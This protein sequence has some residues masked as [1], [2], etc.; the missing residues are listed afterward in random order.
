MISNAGS[1]TS[2]KSK[3]LSYYENVLPKL[4]VHVIW[5]RNIILSVELV[6]INCPGQTVIIKTLI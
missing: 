2:H 5:H 3:T 6:K 4:Y 1:H